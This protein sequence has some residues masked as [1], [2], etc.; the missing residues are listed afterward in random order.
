MPTTEELY[1]ALRR[2]DAAGDTDS[3][4]RLAEHIRT[5]QAAPAPTAKEYEPTLGEKVSQG[6][7]NVLAGGVRGAGSIGATLA[8][9]SDKLKDMVLGEQGGQS[10]NDARRQGMDEA[11]DE[12]GAD[13]GSLAFK[14]TKLGAE[15]A[16]TMGAGGVVANGARAALPSAVAASPRTAQLLAAIQSGGFSTGAP[17]AATLG[18]RAADMGM[19]MVGGGISAGAM[20]G[21]ANPADA[22]AGAAIGALA[23]PL[24]SGLGRIGGAIG[25]KLSSNAAARQSFR[26]PE[27]QAAIESARDVGLVIPPTQAR[28]TMTNR[29]LEGYAGKLTTAQNASARNQ[30]KFNELAAK[31]IGAPDLSPGSIA[32]VREQAGA[33]YERIKGVGAITAD[34]EFRV[35]L[36]KAGALSEA[37]KRDFPELAN[38][39]VERLVSGMASRPGFDSST[40]IEAIKKF[41]F[42]G[43]SLQKSLDPTQKAV[44]K[45]QMKIAGAMEDL[46]D[47]NLQ[48]V[49]AQDLLAGYRQARATFAKVYDVE[50]A[51]NE[52]SRN[53][54][55]RKI[56]K[57]LEKNRPLTGELKTIGQFARTF[58]KAS[59]PVEGMGSL[60]GFSPL[61][62]AAFGGISAAS[63][64]PAMMAGVAARPAARHMVLAP[65]VQNNL[66][67]GMGGF[68]GQVGGLL[69]AGLPDDLMRL[70]YQTAPQTA[71][72]R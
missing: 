56:A 8:W 25:Q 37:M 42:D 3:A 68:G 24:L 54:D 38:A 10:R 67:N 27:M 4:R 51:L 1:A 22:G 58:P 21:L 36:Q 7:L 53:V 47:R 65:F 69:Q 55:A 11:L 18:G 61:D 17:A 6:A 71:T 34:D 59:Q 45:A 52:T 64:N 23:P 57:L 19:R 26:T 35:A 50:K 60:P 49:G 30:S 32:A 28:P 5:V 66:A 39:E 29:L 70:L 62:F 72:S 2:A 46:I 31:A 12:F 63:M 16:G 41:R 15:I 14:G 9:P 13:R 43:S 44:G 40:A 33:A 20:T 48:Q